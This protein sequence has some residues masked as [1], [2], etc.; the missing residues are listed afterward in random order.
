MVIIDELTGRLAEGR[1]WQLGLHQAIEAKE[2]LQITESTKQAAAITIPSLFKL[3]PFVCG[4][5]GTAHSSRIEFRKVYQKRV[6]R[7]PTHHPPRR[8]EYPA[9]VF[10]DQ[11]QNVFGDRRRDDRDG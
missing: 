5:T 1:K 7:I 11:E 8:V 10:E 6:R 2:G 9:K 3:Y 4:M